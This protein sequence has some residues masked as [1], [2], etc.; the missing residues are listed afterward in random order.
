[1]LRGWLKL[2]LVN[3]KFFEVLALQVPRLTI[4]HSDEDSKVLV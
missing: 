4:N 2:F 3:K 1:M